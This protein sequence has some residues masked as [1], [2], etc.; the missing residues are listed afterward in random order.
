MRLKLKPCSRCKKET[1]MRF[2]NDHCRGCYEV[3]QNEEALRELRHGFVA[4]GA[5]NGRIFEACLDDLTR[6]SVK[7]QDV[8]ELTRLACILSEEFI[9]EPQ[10]WREARALASRL[11]I[12]YSIHD[13]KGSDTI[14][15]LAKDLENEGRPIGPDLPHAERFETVFQE[16]DPTVRKIVWTYLDEITTSRK[17]RKTTLKSAL[18]LERF[19]QSLNGGHLFLPNQDVA[20]AYFDSFNSGVFTTVHEVLTELRRFYRWS[21][22]NGHATENPFEGWYPARLSQPCK[23]CH[24]TS[25]VKNR[26]QVCD[27]CYAS[28]IYLA[29]LDRIVASYRPPS[30]YNRHVFDLY[31][32]CV[33][34]SFIRAPHIAA[35][36]ALIEYLEAN[37]VEAVRT[38]SALDALSD[39]FYKKIKNPAKIVCPITKIGNMLQEVGILP[40]RQTDREGMLE[41]LYARCDL[42]A[43]EL[44]RRYDRHLIQARNSMTGRYGTVRF[45]FELQ[46]WLTLNEP[47]HQLFTLSERTALRYLH[48]LGDRDR[49]GIRRQVLAKFYRWARSERLTLMNPFEGIAVPKFAKIICVCSDQQIGQIERYV[50]NPKSDPEYALL[51]ALVLYWGLTMPEAAMSSID[52]NDRQISIYLH[53]RELSLRRKSHNRDQVLTLPVDPLWLGSLQIRYIQMWRAR[54]EK[55]QKSFPIQPLILKRSAA[56]RTNRHLHSHTVAR[57]FIQ[58]TTAATGKEIPPGVVR[59]TSG[60]IHVD[61]GDASRLTKLGWSKTHAN[62]F[63]FRPRRY[64][65]PKK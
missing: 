44:L 35:A 64:F 1:Q 49:S 3:T 63:S 47:H 16:F 8:K 61:H 59:R 22:K 13:G 65:S 10:T 58:A 18:R 11:A 20:R 40:I 34:R 60:H 4:A 54:F 9:P 12:R 41:M 21:I 31:L 55:T 27:G 52:M 28:V 2:K 37:P 14:L 48:E 39:D 57:L 30:P 32:K 45:V 5:W 33:R 29:K 17:S 23:T 56:A 19:E 26:F 51:L 36:R 6:L 62:G 46:Y 25:I 42:A 24:K 50:K 43:S 38:W 53:R 7:R 15:R